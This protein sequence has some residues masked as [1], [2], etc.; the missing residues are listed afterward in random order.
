MIC[1]FLSLNHQKKIQSQAMDMTSHLSLIKKAIYFS[2]NDKC[3]NQGKNSC[4]NYHFCIFITTE[5]N[6]LL[7]W[8]QM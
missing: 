7:D 3:D 1:I 5:I 8:Q 4:P 2:I 6:C